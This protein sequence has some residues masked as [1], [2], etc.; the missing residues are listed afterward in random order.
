VVAAVSASEIDPVEIDC[1]LRLIEKIFDSLQMSR[2]PSFPLE[3]LSVTQANLWEMDPLRPLR[4]RT[5]SRN[6]ED[7]V[8]ERGEKRF[9]RE[10]GGS[11]GRAEKHEAAF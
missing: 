1:Q 8:R 10:S 2:G 3:E 11:R 4:I 7:E 9:E 5:L 6:A